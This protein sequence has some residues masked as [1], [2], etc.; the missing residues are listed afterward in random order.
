M[1]WM[2]AEIRMGVGL[3]SRSVKCRRDPS[4]EDGSSH[5]WPPILAT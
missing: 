5:S 2:R 4:L 3:E 1:L